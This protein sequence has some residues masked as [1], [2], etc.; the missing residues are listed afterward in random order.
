MQ[1]A[2]GSTKITIC[3]TIEESLM[4]SRPEFLIRYTADETLTHQN[5]KGLSE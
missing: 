3:I 1:L 5:K 2:G 4:M